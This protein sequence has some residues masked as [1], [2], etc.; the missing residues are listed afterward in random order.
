MVT[1]LLGITLADLST[2]LV[3]TDMNIIHAINLDGGGSSMLYY[4][5]PGAQSPFMLPSIDPVPAVLAVYAR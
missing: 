3:T 5:T 1:P 2:Y 4:H